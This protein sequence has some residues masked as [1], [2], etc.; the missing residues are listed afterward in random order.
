[1]PSRGFAATPVPH[2]ILSDIHGNLEALEAVL[3]DAAGKYDRILCLGDLV[4][5]GADPNAVV[6]WARGNLS[7]TVRGNHDKA[8]TG[9]E[10]LDQYNLAAR[11]SADWTR[12]ALTP[13]HVEFLKNL[14]R[15]PLRYEDYDMVHGSP[16]DEDEYLVSPFDVAPVRPFLEAQATLFGHTHVQGGFLVARGGIRAI[17]PNGVLELEPQ[18]L[19]LLNPGAVGQP[20]DGDPR[21]AYA[22]YWP[23][24]RLIEYHRAAYDI[25]TAA[26]KIRAA[27]LP[28]SLAQRLFH[29]I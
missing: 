5:Y 15:G 27:G 10:P 9:K 25:A 13:G 1:M 18:H 20:R 17:V 16:A 6:E 4:G 23:Q 29:G 8:C 22:L 28:D 14:P 24:E 19:Y 26:Q 2:L 12:A 3:A 21:A 7:V 11:L